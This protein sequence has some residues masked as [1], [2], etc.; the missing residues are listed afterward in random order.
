[1]EAVYAVG[2]IAMQASLVLW[3]TT[4]RMAR[5]FAEARMLDV[6]LNEL[7]VN[8]RPTVIDAR[9]M[10]RFQP[11]AGVVATAPAVDPIRTAA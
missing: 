7:S 3:P 5:E 11:V 4:Y 1:L 8:Y 10:K 6:K 9:N 2:S